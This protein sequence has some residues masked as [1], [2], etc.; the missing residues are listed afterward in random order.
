MKYLLITFLF[1]A[2]LL[3]ASDS[4]LESSIYKAISIDLTKSEKPKI[5]IYKE[6]V[7]LQKYH[8]NIEVVAKCEDAEIIVIS[9]LNEFPGNCNGKIVL[10]SRYA[11]LKDKRVVGSFFWQKGRP[12]IVFYADRLAEHNITLSED[13][14]KYVEHD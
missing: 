11:H 6:I 9:T 5:Y 1:F 13:F 10:G 14:Q 2:M 12:N 8:N 3:T 7:S 4:T